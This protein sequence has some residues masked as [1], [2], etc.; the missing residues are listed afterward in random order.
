MT[1]V[2]YHSAPPSRPARI[3]ALTLKQDTLIT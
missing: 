1:V 2:R 3:G